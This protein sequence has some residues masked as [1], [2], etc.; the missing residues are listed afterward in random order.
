LIHKEKAA[1]YAYDEAAAQYRSA[2]LTAFQNVADT[3]NALEQDADTLKAAAASAAAAKVTFDLTRRLVQGG[4]AGTL[5]L[6]T[7]EIA[8]QQAVMNLVQA[9]S[10]RFIDTAALFQALGGGWWNTPAGAPVPPSDH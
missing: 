6:S 7:A 10:S 3:L 5:A 1:R 8:Y 4:Y 2:V 9:Q